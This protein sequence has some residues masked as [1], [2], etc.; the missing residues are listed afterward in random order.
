MANSGD[1][2]LPVQLIL[3][4]PH[5]PMGKMLTRAEMEEICQMLE[6]HPHVIVLSDEVR[7]PSLAMDHMG[8]AV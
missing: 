6:R 4:T 8:I 3:N 1:W 2:C 7:T 5:N